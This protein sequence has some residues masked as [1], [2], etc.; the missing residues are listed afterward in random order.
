MEDVEEKKDGGFNFDEELDNMLEMQEDPEE[1]G[2]DKDYD[3]TK[4]RTDSLNYYANNDE[5]A[6]SMASNPYL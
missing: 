2:F 3:K 4:Q 6:D 5:R 1:L